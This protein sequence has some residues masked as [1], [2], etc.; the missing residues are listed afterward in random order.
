MCR[1]PP[2]FPGDGSMPSPKRIRRD[3]TVV[4]VLLLTLA[5]VP[6]AAQDVLPRPE[7]PYKGKI[8]RT[9]KDSKPDFPKE[10][11]PP[12]GAP[13]VLLILTDDVGFGASSPFGGPIRTPTF[14]RVADAGLRY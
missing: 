10:V 7:P 1:P 4:F 9:A 2:R 3:P 13:N 14:Q 8:G 11:E 12:K 6:V 5:P